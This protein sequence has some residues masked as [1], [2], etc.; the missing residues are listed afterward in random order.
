MLK[1]ADV[2]QKQFLFKK[3]FQYVYQLGY[4]RVF[5]ET[6][7]TF[8]N[9]LLNYKLLNILYIF[10]SNIMLKKFGLNNSTH[11]YLRKIKL[12]KKIKINLIN[13]SL[14]RKEF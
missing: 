1:I 12:K 7:L 6:G 2:F 13:D 3:L 4:C 14:Y 10:Q 11:H 8:L 5:F 9:V